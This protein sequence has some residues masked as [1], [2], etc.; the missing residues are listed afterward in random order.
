MKMA[1][2][3]LKNAAEARL[4]ARKNYIEERLK[5]LAGDLSS[6]NEAQL[7]SI[8]K[9]LY[10][11]LSDTEEARYDLEMRIRKQDYDVNTRQVS[12]P[13]NDVLLFRSMN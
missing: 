6:M 1:T 10:K 2:E 5:P 4:S 9:E 11:Q 7:V 13:L 3:N 12:R 8:V